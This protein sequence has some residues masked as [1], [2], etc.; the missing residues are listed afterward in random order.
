MAGLEQE[1][2]QVRRQRLARAGPCRDAAGTCGM[3]RLTPVR[4]DL[5]T[6]RHEERLVVGDRRP[7]RVR[8]VCHSIA[9]RDAAQGA[10]GPADRDLVGAGQPRTSSATFDHHAQPRRT[11]TSSS[12]GTAALPLEAYS[13]PLQIVRRAGRPREEHVTGSPGRR[14]SVRPQ[15]RRPAATLIAESQELARAGTWTR[16]G[17]PGGRGGG[18]GALLW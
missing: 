2:G 13:S 5:A 11:P 12:T 3:R 18:F 14:R 15:S 7:I 1:V 6:L 16:V 10:A 4:A 9:S 17:W 8:S